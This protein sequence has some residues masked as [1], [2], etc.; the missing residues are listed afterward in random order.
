[1]C[2]ASDSGYAQALARRSWLPRPLLWLLWS[3]VIS[4]GY[5][6][7]SLRGR[8]GPSAWQQVRAL[9]LYLPACTM[10]LLS[11]VGFILLE[12]C[13]R[14]ARGSCGSSSAVFFDGGG[15]E[16]RWSVARCVRWVGETA[17]RPWR[18]VENAESEC[19]HVHDSAHD[20]EAAAHADRVPLLG[21]SSC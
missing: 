18:R 1:M 6:H 13:T 16:G 17:P 9:A 15:T 14:C 7:R 20:T 19:V 8:R 10:Y 21:A 12:L 2:I 5:A 3:F 4:T 11:A